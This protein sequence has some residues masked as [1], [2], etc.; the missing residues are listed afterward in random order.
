MGGII[1]LKM[2]LAAEDDKMLFITLV[3]FILLLTGNQR[4]SADF[5]TVQFPRAHAFR[6]SA[7]PSLWL[8]CLK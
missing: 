7:Q 6:A 2:F 5:N 8:P 1:F 4:Q 3:N